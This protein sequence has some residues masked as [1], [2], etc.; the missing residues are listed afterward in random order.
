MKQSLYL[1]I[2]V[3]KGYADC[4]MIDCN[5]ALIEPVFQLNDTPEGHNHLEQILRGYISTNPDVEILCGLESTGGYER[6]WY[7]Y[8]LNLSDKLPLKVA[9]INP[10]AI[11]GISKA[12]LNRTVT[13]DTSA[14]NIA[15]YLVSY[16]NRIHFGIN[17]SASLNNGRSMYTYLRMQIKQKVQ[18]SNQLEKLLYQHFSESLVY[19]RHGIPKWLLN[20]LQKYPSAQK[21]KKA[22]I[23]RLIKIKGVGPEKAT[24]LL[25]KASCNQQHADMHIEF[26]IKNTCAEILHKEEKI[27]E[28]N[29]FLMQRYKDNYWVVLLCSIPGIGYSSAISIL[30]EIENIERFPSAKKMAAYFGVN[31]QF[32]Q[33]GDG[34]WEC[35]MSKKGRK[36]IRGVLYMACLTTVRH[37]PYMKKKYADI[38]AKNNGHY[39][40]MGVLMHKMLRVIYGVMKSQT[41]YDLA[42]DQKNRD[43]AP[44][45]QADVL[46]QKKQQIKENL[47]KKRRYQK[48]EILNAPISRRKERKIKE[49]ES[50]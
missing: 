8:L 23:D 3:S 50:S 4:V 11:K 29:S 13:D 31:P 19:C 9:I 21:I 44:E 16:S 42:I 39:F 28:G 24:S 32:K 43:K 26:I 22:G 18:L 34:T 30:F 45:K 17:D 7:N 25:K 46:A 5:H 20:T 37:D 27:A 47:K 38:R 1:G 36:T 14:M 49:L 35:H 15:N 12:S 6:N 10:V 41:P 40:A 33:S 2:D 48:Q